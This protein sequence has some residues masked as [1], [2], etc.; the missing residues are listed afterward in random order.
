[1]IKI[2][3]NGPE[4]IHLCLK[5]QQTPQLCFMGAVSW[6][7]I[8]YSGLQGSATSHT[9]I[10][11]FNFY[12]SFSPKAHNMVHLQF[13]CSLHIHEGNSWTD[14]LTPPLRPTALNAEEKTQKILLFF[15]TFVVFRRKPFRNISL[16]PH[17]IMSA[18]ETRSLHCMSPLRN[19]FS[20]I[21][22]VLYCRLLTNNLNVFL[23]WSTCCFGIITTHIIKRW[24]SDT[25]VSCQ[26]HRL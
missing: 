23:N 8:C 3:K 7:E 19:V 14:W 24:A 6:P 22:H 5:W 12:I 26:D 2:L 15:C 21:L 25:P 17:E 11:L 13:R 20:E 16:A 10:E 9:H 18:C 4:S 1:M